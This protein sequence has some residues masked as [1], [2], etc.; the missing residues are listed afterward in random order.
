MKRIALAGA[1]IALPLVGLAVPADAAGRQIFHQDECFTQQEPELCVDNHIAYR[2]EVL[3]NGEYRLQF[4]QVVVFTFSYADGRVVS[5]R[6]TEQEKLTFR[7]GVFA[8][9]FHLRIR[10]RA[11][12]CVETVHFKRADNRVLIDTV[13]L[14]CSA[15]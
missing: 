6:I 4:N 15:G 3:P 14:R 11:A 8:E 9:S 10:T 2:D 1:L 5:E 13:D 7:D 12:N